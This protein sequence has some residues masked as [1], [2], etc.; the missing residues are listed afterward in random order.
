MLLCAGWGSNQ[1][2]PMLLVYHRSLGL[3]TGTLEAM[4][5]FYAL[6]LVPGLLV[7]GTLSETRGR[8]PV[9]L[10][11]AAFGLA[12]SVVLLAAGHSTTLLFVGRFL[13]GLSSGA[14][15]GTGTVWL[16]ELSLEPWG[17]TAAPAIA[18]R[19]VVAMTI[20][21]ALGP[22]VSGV[23]ARWGPLPRALPFAPHI[24]L[25]ATVFIALVTVPETLST[26]SRGQ[27]FETL[28]RSLPAMRKPR[29]RR[30]LIP[31]APWVFAAPAIAFALLPSIVGGSGILLTAGITA[32]TSFAGVA[33]QAVAR[34]L[35]ARGGSRLAAITGL[36]A[37]VAG[38]LVGALAAQEQSTWL[39]VPTSV[40]FG[41]AYGLCLV[42]GLADVQQ[43]ADAEAQAGLTAVYYTV[44]YVGFAAPY[45]IALAVGVASYSLLLLVTG[46]LALATLVQVAH[47]SRS[48]PS[49]DEPSPT[50][51]G[52]AA[53]A[54]RLRP[55]DDDEFAAWLP[56]VRQG[57]VDDMIRSGGVSPAHAAAKA[58]A[59]TDALF[60]S[61]RP[62]PLQSV[63][64]IEAEGQPAGDLWVAE[65]S[66]DARRYLWVYDVHI[67]DEYRGRG[68]GKAA[69]VLAEGEARRRGLSRVGLNVFGGNTT[70]RRL[71]LSLGYEE[72]AIEMY[73]SI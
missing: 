34:R 53:M 18:R 47:A 44:M 10:V 55:M 9:V 14:A 20:G 38:T 37:F 62:S 43:L 72:T 70:A 3:S 15:F 35:E 58:A 25:S 45:L 29:F 51:A 73:K 40:L 56:R 49:R 1:F 59:E 68:Y 41:G 7:G 6:G 66:D 31:M 57:Y 26:D 67:Q 28:R 69:M 23:L 65:R 22:I 63:F 61:G 46:A 33:A 13:I 24:V 50:A 36:M 11:A 52:D 8:R 27:P 4:F 30:V 39:L 21:F 42:A 17:H 60:P 2:T 16:R 19:T 64:V 32:L 48:S 5:G 12:G 54:V 71:Y